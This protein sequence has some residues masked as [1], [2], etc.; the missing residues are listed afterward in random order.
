VEPVAVPGTRH[1]RVLWVRD[2]WDDPTTEFV[3]PPVAPPR[4]LRR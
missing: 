3:E 4:R 1:G 2:E